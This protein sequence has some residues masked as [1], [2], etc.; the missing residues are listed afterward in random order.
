MKGMKKILMVL[1]V[2][3]MVVVFAGQAIAASKWRTV[4]VLSTTTSDQGAVEVVVEMN[5]K[6]RTFTVPLGQENKMLSMAMSAQA[7]SLQLSIFVDFGVDGSEIGGMA[8]L[9]PTP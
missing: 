7:S 9:S 4:N 2:L 5:G 8:L 6:F 3:S 1:L